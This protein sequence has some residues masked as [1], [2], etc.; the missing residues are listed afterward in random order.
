[1]RV[2]E[3]W[4]LPGGDGEICMGIWGRDRGNL[5]SRAGTSEVNSP[6]AC[7]EAGS[8]ARVA[9][10]LL[11]ACCKPKESVRSQVLAC[12]SMPS[13]RQVTLS[14]DQHWQVLIMC[15]ANLA[16]T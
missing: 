7:I 4:K 8:A 5:R 9:A 11:H 2:D 3:E 16:S 13:C 10:S 14:Y 15:F 1:M 6:Q 12:E